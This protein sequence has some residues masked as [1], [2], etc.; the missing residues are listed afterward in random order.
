MDQAGTFNG[1]DVVGG[2]DLVAFRPRHLALGGVLVACEVRE[3][4][5]VTPAF[6]FGALKLAHDLV[7][8]AKF[9]LVG[10]KQR[11]AEVELL[12]SELAFGR[13]HL[14]VVDVSADHDGEV[15]RNGPR[16]GGPEDG[17]G[18]LL[19]AQLHG[20][21][22]GGVLTV[23]IHVGVHAQLVRGQRRLVLRAVRQHA[24]AW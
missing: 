3:D 15:G 1:V 5:V 8:L 11:L 19:V 4:R 21:G 6:H 20:H 2:E 23:L 17:V 12:A 24:V 22:H 7:V 14:D 16:S 18:I 13:T 9:L 10:A